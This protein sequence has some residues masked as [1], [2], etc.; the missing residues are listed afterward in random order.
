MNLP[1][2]VLSPSMI[3]TTTEYNTKLIWIFLYWYA[4]E[5]PILIVRNIFL[6][7]ESVSLIFSFQFLLKTLFYPWKNQLYAY[8]NRGFDI[9]RILEIWTNNTISRVVGAFVRLATILI[10]LVIIIFTMIIGSLFLILWL[11]YPVLF[12]TLT[13]ISFTGV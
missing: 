2:T 6:Y 10:G 9:K 5:M 8:P 12:I 11:T 3:V 7:I 1:L 13:I 4:K